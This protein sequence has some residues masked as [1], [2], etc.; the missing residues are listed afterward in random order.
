MLTI[1]PIDTIYHAFLCCVCVGQIA[2]QTQAR[3]R[4]RYTVSQVQMQCSH[5]QVLHYSHWTCF[6][7]PLL[8]HTLFMIAALV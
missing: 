2:E 6:P 4:V 7:L 5:V 8:V 1:R 3:E